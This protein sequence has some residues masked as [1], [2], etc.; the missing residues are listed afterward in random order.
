M[1]ETTAGAG[2]MIP[3]LLLRTAAL[4]LTW[5]ILT[6]GDL[7]SLSFGVPVAIV[8]S[9]ISLPLAPPHHMR[10]RLAGVLP[11]AVY[12]ITKSVAGGVDVAR[13]ALTPSMPIDPALVEYHISLTGSAPRVV[14]ANTISLL[15][16]TLTARFVDDTLQVHALDA[17]TSVHAAL[18]EL[19]IRVGALYGQSI[20]RDEHA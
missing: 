20:P 7:S 16:G 10:L 2:R 8:A 12:F 15:P 18:R 6:G 9:L 11:Y 13:R 17:T 4:V 14:F 3:S 19:E 1:G 5:W